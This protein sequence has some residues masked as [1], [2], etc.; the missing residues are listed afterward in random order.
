M[1]TLTVY[2]IFPK[3]KDGDIAG[4]YIGSTFGKLELRIKNHLRFDKKPNQKELHNLM[5][6]NGFIY[7]SLES[8]LEWRNRSLEYDWVDYY[9]QKTNLRVFNKYFGK[10][11]Y[12]NCCYGK[13]GKQP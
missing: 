10:G 12:K 2:A 8:K 4:V 13:V 7:Q 5:K 1:Y 11:N 3:D 9:R 6:N